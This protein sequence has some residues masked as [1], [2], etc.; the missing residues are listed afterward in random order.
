MASEM[1][2]NIVRQR[3][4]QDSGMKALVEGFHEAIEKRAAPPIPYREIM[5]TS[6]IMDAVFDQIR[7]PSRT[8]EKVSA[9]VQ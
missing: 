1:P 7:T 9:L 8:T 5:L 2:T 3:L 6:R 4:H